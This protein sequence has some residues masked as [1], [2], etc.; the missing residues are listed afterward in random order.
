MCKHTYVCMHT[1][2]F[3]CTYTFKCIRRN[4]DNAFVVHVLLQTCTEDTNSNDQRKID[5]FE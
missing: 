3:A 4:L 1:C 5:K 2:I